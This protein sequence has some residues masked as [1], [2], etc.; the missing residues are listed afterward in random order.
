MA[1]TLCLADTSARINSPRKCSR[2]QT[3]PT[4]TTWGM[5]GLLLSHPGLEHQ[6]V[7]QLML[8]VVSSRQVLL[9]GPPDRNRVEIASLGEGAR[10]EQLFSPVSQWTSK[11]RFNR[12]AK[13]HL[14]SFNQLTRYVLVEYL[15]EE[16]LAPSVAHF[17][18][19]WQLPRKL[20]DSMIE[21][22]H[23]RLQRDRHRG[24]IDFAED[25]VRE[26]RHRIEHHHALRADEAVA[27][28]VPC[29]EEV[30]CPPPANDRWCRPD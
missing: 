23:A 12:D 27:D 4:I 13:A 22:W 1:V 8:P 24:A 20:D 14:R 11:P 5:S 2:D 16:P 6:D 15:S 18:A 10:S 26:I 19:K 21:K 3:G 30:G 28:R 17:H 7:Q 29:C 9:P 25:V